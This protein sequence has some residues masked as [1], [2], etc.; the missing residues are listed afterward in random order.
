M[1]VLVCDN[2]SPKGIQILKNEKGLT[3]D[4]KTGM[5]PDELIA[6]VPGYNALIIRSSTRATAEVME[7]GKDLKVIGRAGVGLDNVDVEAATKRGIVVMNAPGGNTITT[8]EHAVA[9]LMAVSRNIPQAAVSMKHNKWEKK[10]FMGVEV[11]G[12]RLGV[13]GLGRI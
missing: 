10:K 2:L 4:I 9:M 1:K 11:F 13:I 12:K 5:K 3:V 8:A 6:A 7:A